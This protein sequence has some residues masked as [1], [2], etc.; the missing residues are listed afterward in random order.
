V[1]RV[2]LIFVDGLGLGPPDPE[3]N[4]LRNPRFLVLG[5]YRDDGWCAP[6]DGGTPD[7]LP[8]VLRDAPLPHHGRVVVTDASLGL[9]GLPQSATGQTTLLTGINAGQ[10]IGRHLFGFPNRELREIIARSSVL[11]RVV[12][13]GGRATFLNA[14]RPRFFEFGD[15]VFKRRRLS[16][17]TWVNHA[18]GLPFRTVDDL[19]AGRAVYQDITHDSLAAHGVHIAPRPP[20]E[21]G[22]IL[23]RVAPEHDLTLFEFFQTDRAG[24]AQDR[25]KADRE[26]DKLERFLGTVLAQVDLATTAVILTSDHGN[27]EDLAAKTHTTNPVPTL[28][29]GDL[30]AGWPERLDSLERIT[31]AILELLGIA[32]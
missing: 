21:A 11:K 25:D 17:T 1:K 5:N 2:I 4:P 18:A 7:S 14:F 31:P 20:E 8:A 24:H 22:A 26:L 19:E 13:V 12:D 10:A 28:V 32:A 6:P 29:F 30:P 3:R 16:A 9:P 15:E 23:A 27:I